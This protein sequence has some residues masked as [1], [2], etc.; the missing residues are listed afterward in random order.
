MDDE[1]EFQRCDW[2]EEEKTSVKFC[3]GCCRA[4]YCS[5][6][7]QKK[8][9]Q[10]VHKFLCEISTISVAA[11]PNMLSHVELQTIDYIDKVVDSSMPYYVRLNILK[12]MS[13]RQLLLLPRL[14]GFDWV[15]KLMRED[16]ERGKLS[17]LGLIAFRNIMIID[18]NKR[19]I[20]RT[21]SLQFLKCEDAYM[22]LVTYGR[23]IWNNRGR[24]TYLMEDCHFIW[25][26]I[27]EMLSYRSSAREILLIIERDKDDTIISNI[28]AMLDLKDYADHIEE[29]VWQSVALLKL[30]AE[31]LTQLSKTSEIFDINCHE[32]IFEASGLSRKSTL[33]RLFQSIALPGGLELMESADKDIL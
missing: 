2:C 23:W 25:F 27:N 5:V 10:G 12:G 16:T 24:G 11:N 17:T 1:I 26:S 33:F 28:A 6:E 8:H 29:L 31:K 19:W 13:R 21:F 20:D 30:Q 14:R 32:R 18:P 3:T 9:W 4:K 22:T 15:I 7:C